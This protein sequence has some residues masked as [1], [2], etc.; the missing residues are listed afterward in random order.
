MENEEVKLKTIK[1]RNRF[2]NGV[3]NLSGFVAEG[4][5]GKVKKISNR[6]GKIKPDTIAQGVIIAGALAGMIGSGKFLAG[7]SQKM[8]DEADSKNAAVMENFEQESINYEALKLAL[9]ENEIQVPELAEFIKL[10][11]ARLQKTPP[12]EGKLPVV[13]LGVL[14]G[15]LGGGFGG[16]VTA[17]LCLGISVSYEKLQK[18]A[19]SYKKYV[20]RKE[21]E[22][23]DETAE[24]QSPTEIDIEALR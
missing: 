16:L 18:I 4:V 6:V 23:T 24:P 1:H 14:G 11:D 19:V 2:I 12:L 13:G 10:A 20:R 17:L 5:S 7:V 21:E 8:N 22:Q 15:V 3:K 9:L